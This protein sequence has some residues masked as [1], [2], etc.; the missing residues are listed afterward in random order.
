MYFCWNTCLSA[1]ITYG[2]FPPWTI[3]IFFLSLFLSFSLAGIDKRET[4][5]DKPSERRL[6]G[7]KSKARR[8][9]LVRANHLVCIHLQGILF[10]AISPRTRR[11]FFP[12]R[13]QDWR[14]IHLDGR[15]KTGAK[16]RSHSSSLFSLSFSLSFLLVS[17]K[18]ILPSHD[19]VLQERL[20]FII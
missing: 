9:G 4:V 19:D 11:F 17:E 8:D 2:C 14:V 15:R 10:S 20:I 6:R 13:N 5:R 1:I 12:F 16:K 18:R 3:R 7:W